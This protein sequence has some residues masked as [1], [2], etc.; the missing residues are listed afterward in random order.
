MVAVDRRIGALFAVFLVLLLLAALRATWL[1]TVRSHDLKGR[2]VAQQVEDVQVAAR[3]GTITDRNGVELAVSE[4]STTVFANPMQIKDP[5]KVAARLAPLMGMTEED[6]LRK[7]S[8]RS[9][10]FVYLR[11]KMDPTAGERVVKLKIPGIGTTMEPKRVY[12]QGYLASQV[13]GMVGTDN[14]GLAGLEYAHDDTLRGHDGERR[15]VKDALGK[16]VSVVETKRSAAGE[17]LH[18]TLDA[19]IQERTEAVLS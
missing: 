19:R 14:N 6:L 8:D 15:L 18:L 1:G 17:N 10:G 13:L 9:T 12:P 16:T 4:D 7:L 5:A 11:R 3:R 2:A